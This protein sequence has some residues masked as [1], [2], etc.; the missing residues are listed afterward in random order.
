MRVCVHG[1]G[2]IGLVTASLFANNGH[3]VV[4]FDTDRRIRERLRAG[5]PEVSEAELERFV[6]RALDREFA[7]VDEPEPAEYHLVCVPT[8][9]GAAAGSA[10]LTYVEQASE[11][12]ASLLRPDDVVVLESTVPP[13]TTETLLAPTV[14]ASGLEPGRDV[15]LGYCPETVLPG[16]AV[17]EL[18]SNDRIIGGV[19]RASTEAVEALYRSVPT[20]RLRTAPDAT[21]AEFVKLV[22]NAFRDVNIAFAN[23]LALL[24]DDYDL[25]VRAAIELANTHPRVDIL[26]PG[27][28]VGGHCLPVDPLFLGEGSDRTELVDAARAI[29]DSMPSHVVD[30][31]RAELGGLDGATVAVLGVSYKGN[32]D[33]TRNSPGLAVGRALGATVGQPVPLTDGGERP[34]VDVRFHDPCVSED[35]VAVEL[36]SLPDALRGADA[37]ILA[38]AHD[39]FADLDPRAVGALLDERVVVDPVDLLDREAWTDR[40]FRLV[41]V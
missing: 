15:G 36:R 3:E 22:Q 10:D 18:R 25:P 29:N 14:A 27:P 33:D 9:Y 26:D 7:V 23:S 4:G 2:Y 41:G 40:G 28:G 37:A 17:A 32:V 20:G 35:G 5:D 31:L 30:L 38:A 16:N 39:E 6:E 21:T 1:L 19:D 11:T 24:A 8:P 12:V 34:T 13:G